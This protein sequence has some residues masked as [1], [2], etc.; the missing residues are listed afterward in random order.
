MDIVGFSTRSSSCSRLVAKDIIS[1]YQPISRWGPPVSIA[2]SRNCWAM[3]SGPACRAVDNE[4]HWD[5]LGPLTAA[6][7][8]TPAGAESPEK[9]MDFGWFNTLFYRDYQGINDCM[10]LGY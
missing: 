5:F 3:A 8:T 1:P 10:I 4:I 7:A 6:E 9:W 2:L